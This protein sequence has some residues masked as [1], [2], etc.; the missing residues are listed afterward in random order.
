MCKI[1]VHYSYKT[2]LCIDIIIA[3]YKFIY[4]IGQGI[5]NVTSQVSLY[6]KHISNAYM[7]KRTIYY[8]IDKH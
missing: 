3:S 5:N 8:N 7:R 2:Y 1:L 4:N 6:N